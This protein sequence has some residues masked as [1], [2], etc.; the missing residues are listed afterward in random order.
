[1]TD[2]LSGSQITELNPIAA[3]TNATT[4]EK[5]VFKTEYFCYMYF[6]FSITKLF[7][8]VAIM[9]ADLPTPRS[10]SSV[11]ALLTGIGS[12]STSGLL[13]T[14]DI[15]VIKSTGITFEGRFNSYQLSCL[16]SI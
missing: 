11:P 7:S 1:M 8:S 12:T 2:A 14:Y 15:A 5:Y 4:N 10:S 6:R 9:I 3:L 13:T 16:Y